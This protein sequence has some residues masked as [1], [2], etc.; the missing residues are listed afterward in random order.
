MKELDDFRLLADGIRKKKGRMDATEREKASQ[1]IA[2]ILKNPDEQ[3]PHV[4]PVVEELQSDAVADGVGVAW[5]SLQSER[6]LEIRRWLPA[7]R[8][9]RAQRRIALIASRI[10]ETDGTT[11]LDLLDRLIPEHQLSKELRQVLITSLLANERTLRFESLCDTPSTKSLRVLR[12]LAMLAFDATSA[13]DPLTRY[14][15]SV[16][17]L[18]VL[19]TQKL[20][21]AALGKDLISRMVIEV[22]RWPGGLREQFGAWVKKEAAHL[23]QEFFPLTQTASLTPTPKNTNEPKVERNQEMPV[24]NLDEYLERRAQSLATESQVLGHLR[25]LIASGRTEVERQNAKWQEKESELKARVIELEST[26]VNLEKK[27]ADAARRLVELEGALVRAESEKANEQDRLSRQI[28]INASGRVDEFKN[29]LGLILSRQLI[30]LPDRDT[31]VNAE[32]GRVLLLQFHQLIQLLEE[33]GIN[34]D[35][36]RSARQ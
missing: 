27:L 34:L 21:Q 13:V 9:E 11:A 16:A 19:V 24:M 3:L 17:I 32:L 12:V 28:S 33:L 31:D 7:P 36:T 6:R 2:A 5:P 23:L 26:R 20:E 14:R 4:L 8:T 35:A 1:F 10:A 25:A 18:K 22:E 29:Q 15:L 30:D